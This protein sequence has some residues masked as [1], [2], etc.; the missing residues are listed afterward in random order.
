MTLFLYFP[1]SIFILCFFHMAFYFLYLSK[2]INLRQTIE[3]TIWV[4]KPVKSQCGFYYHLHFE[5]KVQVLS[6]QFSFCLVPSFGSPED[7]FVWIP[8]MRRKQNR[9][10]GCGIFSRCFVDSQYPA[11]I[12]KYDLLLQSC[13]PHLCS[14]PAMWL[15]WLWHGSFNMAI[16]S[17]HI[18]LS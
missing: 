9:D 8:Q 2:V 18:G 7:L 11:T 5:S 17:L 16:S 6:S 13:W 1:E 15:P 12:F 4:M 14:F 10:V 3:Y